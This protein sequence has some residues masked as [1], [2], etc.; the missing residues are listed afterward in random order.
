MVTDEMLLG[1]RKPAQYIGGEWNVSRKDFNSA[2]VKFA[3]CFPDL[4]EVG[5]SNLGI[6][7]LYGLLNSRPELV[8]ERFFAPNI[9]FEAVLRNNKEECF[10]LESRK[11]LR[12]FD[13]AGFSLGYELCYTNVLNILELGNI[14][15]ESSSRDEKFPLVIGGGP[16][17]MNPEP[18]ADFFDLFVIGEAEEAILEITEVYRKFKAEYKSGKIKKEGLLLELARVEGVYAPSL[19][20]VEYD[21][22]GRIKVFQAKFPG[23]P[24]KVKKRFVADLDKSYFPA[25]WLVPYIQTVHDRLTIEIMR[26]CPN[27]CRFCQARSQY[28]PLRYRRPQAV[29]ELAQQAYKSTGYEELSL[30]GLSVSDYPELEE[31]L[32]PLVWEFRNRG[33]S[34]SLPSIKPKA[35]LGE[36][37]NLIA[38]IKKMGLTFAP[39]AG[40][41]RLRGIIGKDF[42]EDDFWKT[43]EKSYA[44]GYQH[45]KLYFMFGLPFEDERD[46]EAIADFCKRVS[47]MRRLSSKWPAQV[48]I[49]VNTMIPKPH[50]PFQWHAMMGLEKMA[51]KQDYLRARIKNRSLKLSFH[52]RLMSFLE[53]V[54]SRGDRRIAPAIASAFKKG[55][56]F[57]GW[58]EHFKFQVWE[59]AFREHGINPGDYLR[60]RSLDEILPWDF[61]DVGVSKGYLV[62]E[63]RKI[64][65][66]FL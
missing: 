34:V 43:L 56:R 49:S 6:R 26:G 4:Y 48:N 24:E 31:L 54:F 41:E 30:L 20:K 16:C 25:N 52:N 64:Q 10:S 32:K 40:S 65:D 58:D 27:R 29:L 11:A 13:I 15:L 21:E 46:L 14:P 3:L 37:T 47:Q 18:M 61:L 35:M 9:D 51:E 36:M 12:E 63:Y 59:E 28:Y 17:V 66:V 44:A 8:C 55:C 2:E 19:Y 39:E 33:V 22:Q 50:T 38:T 23:V 57:D 7:I 60:E 42:A 5:M 1:A 62:E 53:G 45:V